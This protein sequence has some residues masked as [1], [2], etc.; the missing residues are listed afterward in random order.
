M[1]ETPASRMRREEGVR[2]AAAYAGN[3]N[4]AAVVL[5]G[6]TARG[7]ADRFS[8]LELG[9][10]WLEPPT[11]DDRGA[12][13][14]ALGGDLE[15]L[16]PYDGAE[17]AWFDDWKAG[18]RGNAPKTGISV[19]TVHTTTATVDW[20]LEAA[21]ELHDPADAV[22]SLLSVVV[23]GVPLHGHDV[24]ER[25]RRAGSGYPPGLVRAVVEAHGQIDH[26]WRF[27]MFRGRDNPLLAYG[28]VV[29]IHERL[30][31]TLLA[32][33]RIYF[34]GFKSLDAVAARLNV[35]PSDLVARIR[36]TYGGGQ[37]EAERLVGDL[38]EETYD[39][40]ER[41]VPGVDIERLRSIFRYRR[42]LWD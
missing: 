40:V 14:D 13:I 7:D 33:N 21:L 35:A 15:Q 20:A 25:W 31:R 8:D 39:I 3:P 22:Q 29:D 12:A 16:Y 34:F 18:R 26:F 11:E 24:V 27:E 4:V 30:L 41:H 9:I 42:P 36:R 19:E 37:K 5:G 10:F 32:V 38:V 1:P 28:A 17:R 2:I 23:D 6:S